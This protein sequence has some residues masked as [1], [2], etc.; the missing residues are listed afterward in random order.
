LTL[1]REYFRKRRIKANIHFTH[2]VWVA[3]EQDERK[4]RD[5]KIAEQAKLIEEMRKRKEEMRNDGIKPVPG[6]SL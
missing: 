3:A 4:T 1:R 5:G 6:G 2:A